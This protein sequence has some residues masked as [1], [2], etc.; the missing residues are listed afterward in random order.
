V[1]RFSGLGFGGRGFG[2]GGV[3]RPAGR[4]VRGRRQEQLLRELLQ[5]RTPRL[6]SAWD[7]IV[8]LNRLDFLTS[9]QILASTSTN[10]SRQEQLL[11]ELLRFCTPRLY[12][13]WDQIVTFNRLDWS[14]WTAL[15]FTTSRQILASARN[16][17]G[18][19]QGDLNVR[20][21]MDS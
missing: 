20:A 3:P 4:S 7:Q 9:R 5:V 17:Q 13:A 21:D 8:F 6:Y 19:G 10:Q 18:H 2:F 14:F 16:N 11:R 12:S 1:I 15:I